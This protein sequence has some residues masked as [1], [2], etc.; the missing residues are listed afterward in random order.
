[1]GMALLPCIQDRKPVATPQTSPIDNDTS[2]RLKLLR[3]APIIGV[4]YVHA[5]GKTT[6]YGSETIGRADVNALTD[7]IR[8]LISEGLGRIA[9]PLFFLMAGYLFFA[10]LQ[11]TMEGYLAKMRSRVRTLFVPFIFWNAL[12]LAIILLAQASPVTRPYFN[13]GAK[14]LSEGTPYKYLNALFGFTR[15]PVAYHFWFIR[16]LMVMVLLAP[17]FALILRYAALPFYL[18]VYV[19]WVGNIWPVLVPGDASVF[20]FAAGAHFALKGKSLFALDRF[21]KAALAVYLP[22]L[23]I[24]VVWYEAWFNIYLHRTGLIAGVL[25]VLYA[26]KLIMRNERMTRW[27]VGLGGSSFFVY[28]AHEPLL[29]TLRTIAYRY[30]PLE[31]DFTMLL[32]YLGIPA[33][34]MVL[35]VLLHRLLS[36][37][38]P[39]AL[40]W[41]SGGR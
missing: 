38:F 21:G 18:A 24:D 4:I 35:L 32:L 23:I 16:D 15:Y 37:H 8:V 5:Y 29:G 17:L 33:L 20:F 41:V 10:N 9:V 26:T 25:V 34:V 13:E 27:L 40:G 28:A 2:L 1:M 22:L 12:V 3:F 11:P 6:S 31:G 39:R 19:C 36:L 7:F 30:L 14:L